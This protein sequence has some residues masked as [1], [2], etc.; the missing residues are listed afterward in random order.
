MFVC[1][2]LAS[3]TNFSDQTLFVY[4]SWIQLGMFNGLEARGHDGQ[5]LNGLN[6]FNR[7]Y[8]L[9]PVYK[10]AQIRYK[11]EV[12]FRTS[13]HRPLLSR[14][15]SLNLSPE[16]QSSLQLMDL[17]SLNTIAI[18]DAQREYMDMNEEDALNEENAM[19]EG[20]RNKLDANCF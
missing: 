11:R 9:R 20:G 14:S 4:W 3:A 13:S 12:W 8:P 5:P 10:R 15:L 7:V 2:S 1:R 17:E 16:T 18:L 19:R 6:G